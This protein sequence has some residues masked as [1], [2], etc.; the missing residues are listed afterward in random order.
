M[1]P[2]P[3]TP[4]RW[5]KVEAVFDEAAALPEKNAPRS[6]IGDARTTTACGPRSSRS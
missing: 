4:E 2:Q 5:Q 3:P 1:H 6:W